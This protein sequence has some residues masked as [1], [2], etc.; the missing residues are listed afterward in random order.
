[1]VDQYVMQ[2]GLRGTVT[3]FPAS[4]Q[5]PMFVALVEWDNGHRRLLHDDDEWKKLRSASLSSRIRRGRTSHHLLSLGLVSLG[6]FGFLLSIVGSL[7]GAG[8]VWESLQEVGGGIVA[9][10]VVGAVLH[11]MAERNERRR[12]EHDRELADQDRRHRLVVEL[13]VIR[14]ISSMNLVP[15][16]ATLGVR[17]HP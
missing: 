2:P 5:H 3:D 12:D 6:L 9:G 13:A 16:Q 15:R 10:A 4:V 1:M 11:A 8:S 7:R 17:V 14:D